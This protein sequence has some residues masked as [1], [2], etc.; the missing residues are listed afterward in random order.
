VYDFASNHIPEE[1]LS[2]SEPNPTEEQYHDWVVLRRIGSVGLLWNRSGDAWLGTR[3]IKSADRKAALAR[4]LARGQVMEA[5]VEG[6]KLPLYMRSE[7]RASLDNALHSDAPPP[8]AVILAPLDNLIWDRRFVEELFGFT[9]RWEVYK[10]VAERQYGYYVL[11]ILRGDRFV[12]RFEPG[13]DKASGALVVKKWW[14]EPGVS[15]S[16]RMRSDLRDCFERFLRYLGTDTLH[17]DITTAERAGLDWLASTPWC[18]LR[19][20]VAQEKG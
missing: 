20:E 15:P 1:L 3:G 16:E 4:L 19:T 7:D 14:W 5:R 11:P 12:A 10:P 18:E 17:V 9:Y 2:A 13:R 6:I 8:R